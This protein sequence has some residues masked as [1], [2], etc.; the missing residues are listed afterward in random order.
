MFAVICLDRPV[1]GN[2][3]EAS[4]FSSLVYIALIMG[5]PAYYLPIIE[6]LGSLTYFSSLR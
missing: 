6:A 4:V 5:V 1:I 2:M 3:T